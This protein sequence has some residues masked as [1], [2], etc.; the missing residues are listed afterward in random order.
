MIE[1]AKDDFKIAMLN[2]L[3]KTLEDKEG[4][5]RYEWNEDCSVFSVY[6]DEGEL[7]AA[8]DA[9][10]NATAIFNATAIQALN[11]QSEWKLTIN[12]YDYS[13]E[14]LSKSITIR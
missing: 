14:E 4:E 7:S 12:Y 3:E 6:Y 11:G 1:E 2:S 10:L 5:Y 13:N 8:D 9:R